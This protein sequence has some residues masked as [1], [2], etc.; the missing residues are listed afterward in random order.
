MCEIKTSNVIACFDALLA[1]LYFKLAW[2]TV[3]SLLFETIQQ[4][5]FK[6]A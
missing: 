5:N 3:G 2:H 1:W 4:N 6:P